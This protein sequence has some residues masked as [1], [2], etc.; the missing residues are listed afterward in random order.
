MSTSKYP[1]FTNEELISEI[2][3]R[4]IFFWIYATV[5]TVMVAASI[6]RALRGSFD[7]MTFFP[8]IFV[9]N[10]AMYWFKLKGLLDEAKLRGIA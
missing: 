7:F 1:T 8:L 4:R 10:S 2:K 6:L 9:A 3:K 5:V